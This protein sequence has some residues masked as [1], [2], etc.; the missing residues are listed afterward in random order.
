MNQ[1]FMR[2]ILIALFTCSINAFTLAQGPTKS[3]TQKAAISW[4]TKHPTR[5]YVLPFSMDKAVADELA[6]D[7]S[8]IPKGPLRKAADSRPRVTDA[9]T[10]HDRNTPIGQSIA[11]QVAKN[12]TDAGLPAVFWNQP[13]YPQGEGWRLTGQIVSLNEATKRHKMQS[14]L[15]QETKK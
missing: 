4:P 12:L 8:L 1:S 11:M 3:S 2:I 7:D 14:G 6:K 15:A 10:G 5:I 9:V 13:T